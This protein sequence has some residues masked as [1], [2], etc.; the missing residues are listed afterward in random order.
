M[1][2]EDFWLVLRTDR[3][4]W[5]VN[6]AAIIS[7]GPVGPRWEGTS[8]GPASSLRS[9]QSTNVLQSMNPPI[10]RCIVGN[11]LGRSRPSFRSD[12]VVA[13]SLNW[14]SN[15][16]IGLTSRHACYG[17]VSHRAVWPE[18]WPVFGTRWR[19]VISGFLICLHSP[20]PVYH[21]KR[22]YFSLCQYA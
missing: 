10:L 3:A 16:G 18:T 2:L 7:I 22:L 21:L 4:W 6:K 5:L 19:E 14:D 12:I 17:A 20:N 9:D 1:S 13:A 8:T 11:S 15:L